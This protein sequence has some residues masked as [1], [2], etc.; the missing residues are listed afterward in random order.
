MLAKKIISVDTFYF[1]PFGEYEASIYETN[2]GFE[3]AA[4][5]W[6]LERV[7]ALV[8]AL[9]QQIYL[10]HNL[11]MVNEKNNQDQD[12]TIHISDNHFFSTSVH[13]SEIGHY[14]KKSNFQLH[15]HLRKR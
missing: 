7:D 5:I 12:Y 1:G 2:K 4:N 11:V 8:K 14:K 9:Q 3:I 10:S 13:L 6:A 15:A